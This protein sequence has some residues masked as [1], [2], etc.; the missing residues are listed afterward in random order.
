MLPRLASFLQSTHS[1]RNGV[2]RRAEGFWYTAEEAAYAQL[3]SWLPLC[4]ELPRAITSEIR[5][6]KNSLS[7]SINTT[8]GTKKIQPLAD[9]PAPP[10]EVFCLS[11]ER[12]KRK[13]R[14]ET[15]GEIYK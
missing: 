11:E 9:A 5:D 14:R 12:S 15:Q 7:S 3:E 13:G 6:F 8:F 2:S 4:T 10:P 1:D